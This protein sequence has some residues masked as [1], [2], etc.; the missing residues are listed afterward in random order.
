MMQ[1]CFEFLL[2]AVAST[3]KAPRRCHGAQKNGEPQGGAEAA[4]H[5]VM[6][7]TLGSSSVLSPSSAKPQ[8][9]AGKIQVHT[10]LLHALRGQG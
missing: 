1:I 4:L 10:A 9:R 6:N 2:C 5:L 8:G 3:A 7:L